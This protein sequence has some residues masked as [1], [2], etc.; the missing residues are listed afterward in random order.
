M[1]APNDIEDALTDICNTVT[2]PFWDGCDQGE[3]RYQRCA[4]CQAAIF[5]PAI[6]CRFAEQ[7]SKGFMW[8]DIGLGDWL[9]D[10]DR[11]EEIRRFVPALLDMLTN[12]PAAL[13]KVEQA[14]NFVA[15]RQRDTMT[16]VA[17][18]IQKSRA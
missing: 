8:R 11:D 18:K 6:V 7:T 9:F 14:K 17:G 4:D 16:I 3:L 10:F 5:I 13:R 2:Q 15:Q 12:R 1:L